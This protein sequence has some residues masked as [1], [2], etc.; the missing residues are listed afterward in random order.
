M[1]KRELGYYNDYYWE[2]GLEIVQYVI[3]L[4]KGTPT[5]P[6]E[7]KHKNLSFRYN[8]IAMNQ[9][10]VELFLNSDNP[11]EI[12]LAILCKYTQ[13]E[14]PKIIAQI[15]EK[16]KQKVSN[17]RDLHEHVTDL[18]ILSRLR[19]LQP[20]TKKEV[21]KMPIIY[22]LTKD[23]RFKEGLE[24]GLEKVEAKVNLEKRAS[25]IRM[26]KLNTLSVVVIAEILD[27]PLDFILKIQKELES[28]PTP[29][30]AKKAN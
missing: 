3:Y 5:M 21:D 13:K 19:N 10:D 15:L 2:Y 12:I 29:K 22:D 25:A 11:H 6:T 27:V 14:A 20:Q 24:K 1:D 16:L 23:I 7:I 4:G 30:R 8:M 9:V 18:E 26:L 28:K 17:Q